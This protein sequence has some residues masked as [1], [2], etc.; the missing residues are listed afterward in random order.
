MDQN[1]ALRQFSFPAVG[2]IAAC[3]LSVTLV[4]Q[5]L[6]RDFERVG[7]LNQRSQGWVPASSLQVCQ[8]ASLDRSTVG[9]L[10][11]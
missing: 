11:L 10:L 6:Q 4:E 3:P 9:K 2:A 8:I 7:D 1:L 5:L